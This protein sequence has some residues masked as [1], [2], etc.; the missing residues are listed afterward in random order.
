MIYDR[1]GRLEGATP[2]SED[3]FGQDYFPMDNYENLSDAAIL[4]GE[5]LSYEINDNKIVSVTAP[6][7]IL[8][9]TEQL[10]KLVSRWKV[11]K[12]VD[13]TTSIPSPAGAF[14]YDTGLAYDASRGY[15]WLDASLTAIDNPNA[16]LRTILDEQIP[17]ETNKAFYKGFNLSEDVNNQY[18]WE[19][20]L[21]QGLYSVKIVAG[22]PEEYLN[23]HYHVKVEGF[24][25]IDEAPTDTDR[26][27]QATKTVFVSDGRL[28]ITQGNNAVNNKICY[29]QISKKTLVMDDAD[30]DSSGSG[31]PQIPDP[32]DLDE[33]GFPEHN[34]DELIVKSIG[35]DLRGNMLSD[36]VT[37]YIWNNNNRINSAENK[38]YNTSAAVHP[39]PQFIYYIYDACGRRVAK[40]YDW[41]AGQRPSNLSAN[42]HW[43]SKSMAYDGLGLIEE[44]YIIDGGANKPAA[45]YYYEPQSINRLV[46]TETFNNDGTLKD[47]FVPIIDDRGTLLAVFGSLEG[48]PFTLLEKLYYNSTG[49]CKS[50]DP[51]TNEQN[52]D[53]AG[54]PS[55]S[56]QYIPFGWCGMYRE[57]FTGLYHTHFREYHPTHR[58]WLSEDPAGY[59]DGLNLHHAYIVVNGTD[60][61]GLWNMNGMLNVYKKKYGK[62]GAR[63][64]KLM[65]DEGYVI[66]KR[67]YR[68]NDWSEDRSERVIGIASSWAFTSSNDEAAEQLYDALGDTFDSWSDR[69]GRGS[70]NALTGHLDDENSEWGLNGNCQAK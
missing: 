2:G 9:I 65:Q 10:P 56:S 67:D 70:V 7:K 54:N 17:F 44:R 68:F 25:F 42:S 28:T 13:F 35:Y 41:P 36:G 59:A 11:F 34:R 58:Q 53:L 43:Q 39:V 37:E 26:W 6:R 14:S 19:C 46:L 47:I 23:T 51:I 64:L 31:D 27:I 57:R 16:V 49:L 61:M 4:D 22:D 15:G 33:L 5:D 55:K 45:R 8:D 40:I 62:K 29:V 3:V 38:S 20:Q 12:I 69:M 60:T 32:D 30:G 50:F 52:Q 48:A 24:D 1:L 63:L 18:T 66:E 21:A